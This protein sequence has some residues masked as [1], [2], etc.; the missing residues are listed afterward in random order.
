MGFGIYLN[1]RFDEILGIRCEI[2]RRLEDKVF[3][4]AARK[5]DELLLTEVKFPKSYYQKLFC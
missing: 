1:L 2:K 5:I 4:L 3:G